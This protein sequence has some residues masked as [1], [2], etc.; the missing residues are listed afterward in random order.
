MKKT[1]IILV[2]LLAALTA[3]AQEIRT[4]KG[5]KSVSRI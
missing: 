5:V 4:V 1:V 3:S 2:T